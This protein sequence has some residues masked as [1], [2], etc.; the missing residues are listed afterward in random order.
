[1][2]KGIRTEIDIEAPAER[3]WQ[4]LTDFAS[5]PQWNPFIVQASG[6]PKVGSRLNLRIQPPGSR[7]ITIRP[8]VRRA[9]ANQELRWFGQLWIPG[10]FDGEHC[11]L[12]VHLGP[13]RTRFIQ[14][15]TFRGLLVPLLFRWLGDGTV[16]GFLEMN[17]ALKAR[18]EQR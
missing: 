8:R 16:K 9:E 11:F 14:R 13:T 1:M 4:I 18:A 12:L 15:E 6:E 7:G 3:V 17:R 10:L 2:M 5:F